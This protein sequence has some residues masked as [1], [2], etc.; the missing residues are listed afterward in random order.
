MIYLFDSYY[1]DD[2]VRTACLG[3]ENWTDTAAKLSLVELSP[4]TSEYI[5]GEFYKRELPGI[6]QLL[7]QLELKAADIIVLDSY[8]YLDDAGKPGLGAYLYKALNQKYPVIGVA[9]KHFR[10]LGENARK[11]LRGDSAKPLFVTTA[12]YDVD[13]AAQQITDMVGKY[14]MPDILRLVD[15]LSKGIK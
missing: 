6:L 12:G 3:I 2:A 8:V 15:Q 14:R 11:V 4:I 9:K 5:P 10:T 7:E 1:L 13:L